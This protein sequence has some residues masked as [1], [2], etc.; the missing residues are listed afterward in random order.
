MIASYY[1]WPGGALLA[2]ATVFAVWAGTLSGENWAGQVIWSTFFGVIALILI[3]LAYR[4]S[5]PHQR[6]QN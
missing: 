1:F 5:L 2:L 4:E 6:V 3:V